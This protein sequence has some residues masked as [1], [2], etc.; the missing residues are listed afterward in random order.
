MRSYNAQTE[1]ERGDKL[2]RHL[3]KMARW[4]RDQ[5]LRFNQT[6][7]SELNMELA[8][9]EIYEMTGDYNLDYE[10]GFDAILSPFCVSD[11]LAKH[12][13]STYSYGPGVVGANINIPYPN[14]ISWFDYKADAPTIIELVQEYLN[15]NGEGAELELGVLLEERQIRSA[16]T[17]SGSLEMCMSIIRYYNVIRK[18]LIFMNEDYEKSLTEFSFPQSITCDVQGLMEHL[19]L[20]NFQNRTTILVIGSMHDIPK[21]YQTLV[22]NL[23]WNIVIDFDANPLNGGIR[24]TAVRNTINDRYWSMS[25]VS[26]IAIRDN[27]VEWFKC[28]DYFFKTPKPDVQ[29]MFPGRS[30]LDLGGLKYSRWTDQMFDKLFKQVANEQNPVS[31]LFMYHDSK[32]LEKLI[33][34]AESHFTS[35]VSYK[36]ASVYYWGED[37]RQQLVDNAYYD[38]I[39]DGIDY[40][41][42]FQM[43]PCNLLSFF[44]GFAQYY[45]T[46]QVNTNENSV[47]K[48]PG[49]DG[50]MEIPLN[51]QIRLE[52]YF[53]VLYINCGD[54]DYQIAQEKIQEFHTGAIAPWC[55]FEN[56]EVVNLI[57]DMDYDRW[58]NKVK[59]TLGRMQE[60]GKKVLH[61]IHRPGI[62][63]TTMLRYLGWEF[64]KEYPVLVAQK[65]SRTDVKNVLQDLYDQQSRAFIVLADDD[66]NDLADLETDIKVLP[67]PCVLIIAHRNTTTAV[68][69]QAL[70][71]SSITSD[72][73]NRLKYK[74]K[75]ISSLTEMEMREKEDGYN[76]FIQTDPS[77]KS[78]FFIGLYYL[79]KDFKH[80]PD[81]VARAFKGIYKEEEYRALGYIAFCNI[82]GGG[83]LPKI[84]INKIMGLA[85]GKSYLETTP[86]AKSIL[87]QSKANG[88]TVSYQSKHILI[89]QEVLDI[90]SKHL[91]QDGYRNMLVKWSDQFIDD[92]AKELK[93]AFQ[94]NYRIIF[95][96]IFTRTKDTNGDSEDFSK[97]IQDVAV[98]EYREQ[99]LAKLARTAEEIALINDPENHPAAYVMAAHCYGHLGRL[100]SKRADSTY[101]FLQIGGQ[102]RKWAAGTESRSFMKLTVGGWQRMDTS[103][104][105]RPI[106]SG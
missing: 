47:K 27:L 73:E 68:Q 102:Q 29:S 71:F 45:S 66:Y 55:A 106:M 85:P 34:N 97:L 44:A 103:S 38:D 87:Y 39:R 69:S 4:Y 89:S 76:E 15:M 24:S 95:E 9:K 7:Q 16:L 94:E 20:D 99:I 64:H 30:S 5:Y 13:L 37:H 21:S 75:K 67:R 104:L 105:N 60:G 74:F 86:H 92:V 72:A 91:F 100:Y 46:S 62:G 35:T 2:R 25:T 33:D 56:G 31:I 98:P 14:G 63:G 79:D 17:H 57:S 58:K 96:R 84:F 78:P 93:I 70:T 32:I 53:D 82:Y 81:Y 26:N 51:L 77:M 36:L 48:L 19:D 90:C 18:M 8:D 80:L 49:S 28:G 42:R 12:I 41:D 83:T 10:Y 3:E 1:S 11:F 6:F 88:T 101:I 59:S 54:E 43:Y 23:P 61:L 40:G 52:K 65:Y 50:D 22:A